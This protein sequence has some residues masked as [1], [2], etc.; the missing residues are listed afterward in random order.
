[1]IG[2]P[3]VRSFLFALDA[4]RAHDL[5]LPSLSAAHSLGLSRL[6]CSRPPD[7]PVSCFGLD[8]P[9][10]VGLAAGLDKNGAHAEAL[11]ALGFGF[12]E[13]GTV[14]PKPQPGN[15]KPRMFRLTQHQALINRLGF[16]N[17]GVDQLL[18]NLES[19]SL[20]CP[21]GI[22]I[23]KNKDTA[24]ESAHEDYLIC[25]RKVYARA[26]YVTVNISSPNTQGLRDLQAAEPLN[27]LLGTLLHERESLASQHGQ[28]KP[29]LLK[30]APDLDQAGVDVIARVVETC[31]VDGVIATN[32]TIGRSGVESHRLAKEP[33]GLSGAPLT[34]LALTTQRLLRTALPTD[35][36]IVGV[37]GIVKG[38][39]AADKIN[40]GATLVQIYT[41]FIYRGPNLI[42]ECVESIRKSIALD[43]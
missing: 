6:A 4:E 21:L 42:A 31:A 2:Y 1:M 5:T 38:D 22:N 19:Q 40:A 18:K 7:L 39:H 25:L 15:P 9:N 17:D 16:N 29:I 26:D 33:G 11:A 34:E 8:F 23:G 12:V 30:V 24:N 32:T 41:G 3:L 27:R 20:P 43:A 10:P 35:M 36:P 14:T 28:S 37:G 13:V